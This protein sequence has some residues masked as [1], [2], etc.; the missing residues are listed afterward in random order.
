MTAGEPFAG[1]EQIK[2]CC[3]RLYESDVARFLLG[4]SFHP[5]GLLLTERLG[6]LLGLNAESKVLDV[7]SGTGTS[8]CYLAE[9]FGCQVVGIDYGEQ[10]I[11]QSTAAATDKGLTSRVQFRHADAERLPFLD[12]SFDAVVCE[13]ALCTFPDKPSA[14]RE[15]A[16]VLRHGGGIGLSDLTRGAELPKELDGLLA[17]AACIADAQPMESY[18]AYLNGAG[19][20]VHHT[21]ARDN[22]LTEMVNQVR[23][24]LLGVEI[25]TGLKKLEL[26]DIDLAAAKA[27]AR[28]ALEAI[29]EGKLGYAIIC[30][31]KS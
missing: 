6:V 5:G 16:R 1:Q 14:A 15:F 4:E 30:A 21:E 24:K 18:V 27:V 22:A 11:E 3:A 17:W 31:A 12:G 9:C 10:N 25:L 8:A 26:P 19:L 28:S 7:A 23:I 2:Q 13:C 20:R 29:Q